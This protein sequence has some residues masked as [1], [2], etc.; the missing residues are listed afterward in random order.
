MGEALW[1]AIGDIERR[2]EEIS[3]IGI[4]CPVCGVHIPTKMVEATL[5]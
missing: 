3:H 5:K 2:L 1:E 4:T